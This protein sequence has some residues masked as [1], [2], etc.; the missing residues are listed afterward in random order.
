MRPPLGVIAW[1][2]SSSWPISAWIVRPPRDI[3]QRH[4]VDG[5]LTKHI[6]DGVEVES[7]FLPWSLDAPTPGDGV[8][9]G[10]TLSDRDRSWEHADDRLLCWQHL[11]SLPP[12]AQRIIDLRFFEDR[13]QQEIADE[14]GATQFHVSRLLSRHLGE[15]REK[16]TEAA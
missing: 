7:C 2:M 10:A 6:A 8:P 13:T 11:R 12:R 15:L 16:M 5:S 9:L 4:I 3:Q 14:L 1:S